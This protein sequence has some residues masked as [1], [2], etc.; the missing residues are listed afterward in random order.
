MDN[1]YETNK[2]I[3]NLPYIE[4]SELCKI[5]NEENKWEEL[6]GKQKIIK[7]II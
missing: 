1:T 5:L 6:A 2:Y 4:R 3:Y 7:N